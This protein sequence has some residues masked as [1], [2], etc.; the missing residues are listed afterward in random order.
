VHWK[1]AHADM[2]TLVITSNHKYQVVSLGFFYKLLYATK[3][4][5]ILQATTHITQYIQSYKYNTSMSFVLLYI[6]SDITFFT[7]IFNR[8]LPQHHELPL[9]QPCLR[10]QL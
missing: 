6:C 5:T 2:E 10:C 3:Q 7:E 1:Q 4:H 9:I 8:S